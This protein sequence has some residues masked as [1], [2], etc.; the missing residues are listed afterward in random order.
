[1]IADTRDQVAALNAVIRELRVTAGAVDDTDTV[2]TSGGQRAGA[3]D[4]IVTRR[5]DTGLDVANRD[6]WTVTRIGEDDALAV[7]GE[8]G[9]RTLPADYVREHVQ[10]AYASTVHGVQGD[11]T[12]TVHFALGEHTTTAS[13][14]V[15]MTRGCHVNVAHLVAESSEQARQQW[16]DAFARDRADLGPAHASDLAAAE[17][18]AHYAPHRPVEIALYELRAAWTAE[19]DLAA[20]ECQLE[21]RAA[22]LADVVALTTQRD[23][24]VPALKDAYEQTQLAADDAKEQVDQLEAEIAAQAAGLAATLQQDWDRQRSDA[25]HAAQIVYAGNGRLGQHLIAV[26]RATEHLAAWSIRWQPYLP[27]MPTGTDRVDSRK[28]SA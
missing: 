16:V 2:S 12:D 15:A 23:A 6:T 20:T 9:E 25:R 19:A 18:A 7:T 13:V 17:A 26:R 1:M 24:T 14:Y 11:T 21:S 3:G 4:R 27:T 22:M 5:N 10:L 8:R 28:T